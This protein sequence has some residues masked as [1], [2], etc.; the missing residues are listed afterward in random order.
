EAFARIKGFVER[1]NKTLL[2]VEDNEQQRGAIVDLIGDP[3]VEITAVGSGQEAL[4]A[5]RNRPFDCMVLDLGLP[6]MSGFEFIDRLKNDLEI[7]DIPIVA[8]AGRELTKMEESDLNQIA[9]AIIVKD[10]RSPERLL[11]ETALFLHRVEANLP[12]N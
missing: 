5:L 7:H 10:V 3:D 12:H 1:P 8:Y 9:D 11:A 4:D 2:V 6:D